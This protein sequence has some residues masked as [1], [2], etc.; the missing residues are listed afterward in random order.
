MEYFEEKIKEISNEKDCNNL[1]TKLNELIMNGYSLEQIVD[2]CPKITIYKLIHCLLQYGNNSLYDNWAINKYYDSLRIDSN[3]CLVI[4]DPHIGRLHSKEDSNSYNDPNTYYTNERGIYFAYDY[5]LKNNINKIINLG[6][7]IE[8]N[9]DSLM[10]RLNI[11]QQLEYLERIYPSVNNIKTYIL[12]GNH[13]YNAIYF[14]GINENFYKLCK[15]V[16]LIGVNYGYMLFNNNRIKL[17]HESKQ[18]NFYKNIELPYDFELSGHSHTFALYEESRL[19]K[20]PSISSTCLDQDGV[21]FI[22]LLD[23]ENEYVFRFIDQSGR[24]VS[25]KEK[26]LSKKNR[27]ENG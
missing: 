10:R 7:L 17:S 3:K 1:Y 27:R 22:E 14:D 23:E 26:V 6:D 5:A 13:D 16:K 12:Y 21:G 11:N 2:S 8:G 15:N 19:I 25:S 20:I 4:A 9:S 24:I 18:S